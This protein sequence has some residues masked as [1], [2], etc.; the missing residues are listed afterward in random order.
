M[1]S[2]HFCIMK[3]YRQSQEDSTKALRH[4]HLYDK[5]SCKTGSTLTTNYILRII[6]CNKSSQN[7]QRTKY[8]RDRDIS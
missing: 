3:S 6:A 4:R 2:Y 7:K 5:A 1:N 8:A